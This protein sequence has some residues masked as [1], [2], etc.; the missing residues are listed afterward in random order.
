MQ[1]MQLLQMQ[2]IPNHGISI[3]SIVSNPRI[4]PIVYTSLHACTDIHILAPYTLFLKGH[5]I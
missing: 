4:F 5:G 1:I 3:K 2:D